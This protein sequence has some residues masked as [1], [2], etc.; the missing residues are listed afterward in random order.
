MFILESK[1]KKRRKVNKEET[2]MERYIH[3]YMLYLYLVSKWMA[4]CVQIDKLVQL[5]QDT[6]LA[7][8][9]LGTVVTRLLLGIAIPSCP[10]ANKTSWD[11]CTKLPTLA[12]KVSW[13]SCTKLPTL[14][15]K[16]SLD[17]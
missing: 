11:S 10:L 16:V 14:A 3:Q 1:A 13:D 17:N 9:Q 2:A 15:N 8:E 6:L 5:F 4:T 7:S 12:N